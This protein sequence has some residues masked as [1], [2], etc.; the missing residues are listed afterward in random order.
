MSQKV[1]L[2][3]DTREK[4]LIKELEKEK[5][6]FTISQ[7][8]LGDIIFKKDE[9]IIFIIERKTVNDL[10][11]S[12]CDGRHREQKLRLLGSGISK[13]R[14]MYIIEGNLDLSIDTKISGVPVSTLLGSII[15]TQMRDDIKL[16]KT[17]TLIETTLYIIKLLD[18]FNKDIENY[19]LEEENKISS[20]KYSASLKT[21]K[22]ANMTPE[23]W[24]LSQLSLIPQV[25]EKIASIIV[26]KYKNLTNLTKEYENTPDHLKEKLLSDL[27]YP[28]TSG[29]TR[30]IGDKVS[31]RIYDFIH[32]KSED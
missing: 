10:K 25:T 17:Q 31:K 15:N 24:F 19:F 16:Y 8:E 23:V 6:K 12:I 20:S 18:K 30:R 9:E 28:L 32:G 3:I 27:K 26:D 5:I 22:K 29:K 13:E 14:I 7:L 2:I 4:Y 21:S 11:A 1:E